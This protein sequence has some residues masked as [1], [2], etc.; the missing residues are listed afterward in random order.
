MCD[1]LLCVQSQTETAKNARVLV[2]KRECVCVSVCLLH[3]YKECSKILPDKLD[4]SGQLSLSIAVEHDIWSIWVNPG[5]KMH[6]H[7]HMHGPVNAMLHHAVFLN[8]TLY[9]LFM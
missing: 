7:V 9:S 3:R 1:I 8:V 5:H 4:H 6:A 2:F